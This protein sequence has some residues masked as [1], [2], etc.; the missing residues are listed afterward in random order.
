MLLPEQTR[1]GALS[2]ETRESVIRSQS[3]VYH[4]RFLIQKLI[5]LIKNFVLSGLRK[6]SF[7]IIATSIFVQEIVYL[8]V[9]RAVFPQGLL[10]LIT[11][12]LC[13][14]EQVSLWKPQLFQRYKTNRYK[15]GYRYRY[16]IY[17]SFIC[18]SSINYLSYL[19]T[20]LRERRPRF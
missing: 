12:Y 8:A 4:L 17:V 5:K 11:Y 19:C 13:N 9:R 18:L 6:S 1:N 10:L 2:S 15:Y 3:L 7:N 16:F 20:Y 14:L